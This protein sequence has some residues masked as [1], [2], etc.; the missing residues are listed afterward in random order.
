MKRLR[1]EHIDKIVKTTMPGALQRAA[2]V[3]DLIRLVEIERRLVPRK[4][5]PR[6]VIWQDYLD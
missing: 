1:R 6:E 5:T 3:A 2:G 4:V